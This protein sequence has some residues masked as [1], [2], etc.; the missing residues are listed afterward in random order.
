MRLHVLD[1][2]GGQIRP[3]TEYYYYYYSGTNL[4]SH[5][6]FFPFIDCSLTSIYYYLTSWSTVFKNVEFIQ[7]VKKLLAFCW[8]C[9][10]CYRFHKNASLVRSD[11]RKSSRNSSTNFVIHFHNIV[12]LHLDI[13]SC[14]FMFSNKNLLCI[15]YFCSTSFM[16]PF[17]LSRY[18]KKSCLV[19][20]T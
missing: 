14:L 19:T 6:V 17:S 9:G 13:Q 3:S 4:S 12:P 16:L 20:Y 7:P 5:F 10:I 15:S 1:S 8:T 11:P 18:G 2:V